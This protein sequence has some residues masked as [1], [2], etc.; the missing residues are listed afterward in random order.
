M[1]FSTEDPAETEHSQG[2]QQHVDAH[3]GDGEEEEVLEHPVALLVG[4]LP[5]GGDGGNDDDTTGGQGADG[6]GKGSGGDSRDKLHAVAAGG[7][8][9]NARGG[10]DPAQDAG[11]G[12]QD[13]RCALRTHDAGEEVG[14]QAGVAF[15]CMPNERNLL[16]DYESLGQ[17]EFLICTCKDHPLGRFAQ[18]NPA[19]PYPKLSHSL[20]KNEQ[21]IMMQPQQRTR[22]IMDSI[23]RKEN[24]HYDKVLYTSNLPSIMELVAQGYG[25]SFVFESHLRHRIQTK[26]IDCYSFGKPRV[27]HDFV[28]ATRRSSYI[29]RYTRDFNDIVRR[30]MNSAEAGS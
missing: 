14:N 6:R 5:G 11:G 21:V 2:R 4:G 9:G 27:L 8:I 25:V 20:L 24:I 15:Y 26:P 16:L 19:S 12:G 3:V 17:E 10:A 22:Q 7:E 30:Q 28:A 13:R 18:Q 23:L 1:L 29:S